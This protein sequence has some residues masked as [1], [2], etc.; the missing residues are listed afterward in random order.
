M[1]GFRRHS[2]KLPQLVVKISRV[3]RKEI[4]PPTNSHYHD[5]KNADNTAL[6]KKNILLTTYSQSNIGELFMINI[7]IPLKC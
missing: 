4:P 6:L 3:I 2:Y 5:S 1:N 7:N